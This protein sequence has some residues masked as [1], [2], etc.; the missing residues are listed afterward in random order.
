MNKMVAV[1]LNILTKM[2]KRNYLM[3]EGKILFHLP[4]ALHRGENDWE[5]SKTG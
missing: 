5:K 3:R 4:E 2:G 1:E